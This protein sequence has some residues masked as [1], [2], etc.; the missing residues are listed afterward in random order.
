MILLLLTLFYIFFGLVQNA[1][2]KS[3]VHKLSFTP[4]AY[5]PL[6]YRLSL[7]KLLC[8]AKKKGSNTGNMILTFKNGT[9]YS[10]K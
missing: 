4:A 9:T 10:N 5:L 8:T 6:L 2:K 3:E 7:S 1:K